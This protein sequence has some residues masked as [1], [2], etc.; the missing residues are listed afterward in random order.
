M[1]KSL[2]SPTL[3]LIDATKETPANDEVVLVVHNGRLIPVIFKALEDP[4]WVVQALE[5]G[6]RVFIKTPHWVR[7]P[8][9][10]QFPEYKPELPKSEAKS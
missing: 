4:L 6:K 10:S 8:E 9:L 1:I 2:T 3:K 5:I 7:I